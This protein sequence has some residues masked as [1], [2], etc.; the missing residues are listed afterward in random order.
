MDD[1]KDKASEYFDIKEQIK[2]LRRDLK[3]VTEDHPN[4]DELQQLNKKVKKLRDEIKDTE[5]VKKL[6]EKINELKERQ[7]LLKELIRV[8]L[9]ETSQDEIK[10]NG[11]KLK[12][13]PVLK[14]VSDED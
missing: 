3:A 7:E 13:V 2:A 8:E 9:I 11:K 14:E 10:R 4:Y 5:E 12:L 6:K 1:S